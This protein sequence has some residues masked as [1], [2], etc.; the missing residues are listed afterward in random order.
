M[1]QHLRSLVILAV[2]GVFVGGCAGSSGQ[3]VGGPA[4][5]DPP[6]VEAVTPPADADPAPP[7]AEA[8]PSDP[9]TSPETMPSK[10]TGGVS[11]AGTE[12]QSKVIALDYGSVDVRPR[13]LNAESPA[14][15]RT[16]REA[17]VEGRVLVGVEI[18][19][20]GHP[21]KV[22]VRRSVMM[23]DEAAVE[24]AWEWRFTPALRDGKPIPVKIEIPFDFKLR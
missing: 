20:Q 11:L 13:V 2:V 3:E 14:Y 8:V 15:P 23:L 4:D 18:D 17:K 16:A 12:V 5:A 24:A 22:T 7:E 1:V 6:P 21:Q 19:T 9:V 10:P